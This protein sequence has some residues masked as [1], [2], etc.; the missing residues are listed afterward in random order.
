LTGDEPRPERQG[1]LREF[2]EKQ[3]ADLITAADD[4][5]SRP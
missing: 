1:R 5:L 4:H 3:L 2:I